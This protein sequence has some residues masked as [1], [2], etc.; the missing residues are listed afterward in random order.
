MKKNDSK[1]QP[2]CLIAILIR[3]QSAVRQDIKDT[4]KC[5]RLNKKH[6]A[7]FYA[8][9]PQTNGMLNKTKD[10]LTWGEAKPET[11][12]LILAKRAEV[13]KGKKLNAE[14]AK[15]LGYASIDELAEALVEGN[16]P[17]DKFWDSG[18]KPVFRLH[19]PIGGF[20]GTI[21]HSYVSGGELGYRG[22]AIN[23]L[24]LQ[25]I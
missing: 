24:V 4:L 17:L 20:K 25:M 13:T 22:E 16:L 14:F 5:L 18:V 7:S 2:K 9:E 23:D 3:G 11:V 10:F 19:P 21:R 8:N 6:H 1:Q 15:Q 12:K